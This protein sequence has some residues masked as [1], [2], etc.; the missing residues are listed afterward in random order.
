MLAPN[1]EVWL[2]KIIS[3]HVIIKQHLHLAINLIAS[4]TIVVMFRVVEED[5]ALSDVT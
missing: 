3:Y 4:G 1:W 2:L 5:V